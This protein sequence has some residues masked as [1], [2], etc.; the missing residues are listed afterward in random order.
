MGRRYGA[1]RSAGY[2]KR[3]IVIK[4]PG[5]LRKLGYSIHQPREERR[6]AILK[7]VRKYGA[8]SVY[9]K[10]LAQATLRKNRDPKMAER[11]RSDAEFVKEMYKVDGFVS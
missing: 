6:K 5:A 2:S 7:A 3:L 9:R 1:R 10:L 4:R 8:L 11:F